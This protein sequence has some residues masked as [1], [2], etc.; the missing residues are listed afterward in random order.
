MLRTHTRCFIIDLFNRPT[1]IDHTGL[2]Y[3]YQEEIIWTSCI[4]KESLNPGLQST[5][6]ICQV[7]TSLLVL[8]GLISMKDYFTQ[9]MKF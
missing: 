6:I 8:S 1:S 3:L 5:M 2:V 4:L 7:I 9:H